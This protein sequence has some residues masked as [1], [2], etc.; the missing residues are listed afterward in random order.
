MNSMRDIWSR[1]FI[2]YANELQKYMRYV[3]TGHLAIVFVFAIG[4]G[5]YAY[6]EWLKEV[7]ADFPAALLAALIIS[8]FLAFSAPATLL[9]RADIVYF[10]PLEHQFPQYF[11]RALSWSAFSQLPAPLIILVVALP[12]LKAVETASSAAYLLAALLIIALKVLFTGIESCV[13][14]ADE[15]FVWADRILRFAFAFA[16]L[17]ATLQWTIAAVPTAI[18]AALIY[19]KF[20]EKRADKLPF[21]YGHFIELEQNRMMRFYRFA[22]YFTDVPHL[23]GTVSKRNYL[24]PAMKK[25]SFR[26]RDVQTFLVSRT[27]IRTDDTFRLWLRLTALAALGA[28]LIPMPVVSFIYVGALAFATAVQLILALEGGTEFTM[29]ELFPEDAGGSK[30]KAVRKLVRKLIVL[31]AAVLF[32]A[33]LLQFHEAAAPLLIALAAVIIG[34]AT[35]RITKEQER[36]Y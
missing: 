8:S 1:R 21:P 14:I 36:S 5:G 35:I 26:R 25:A 27:F 13:R 17:Y 7:P 31:Q 34:E 32:L 29:D 33:A 19:T 16:A 30:T 24:A 23:A 10:L 15:R 20:W 4:A 18:L 22:N 3:F 9:K 12:L 2:H 28:F 6:S 11:K